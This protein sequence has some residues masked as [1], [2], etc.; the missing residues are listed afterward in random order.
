MITFHCREC[1]ASIE[2]EGSCADHP[3]AIV[4]S[5]SSAPSSLT[6]EEARE[7]GAELETM[8]AEACELF[9]ARYRSTKD[10]LRLIL[11]RFARTSARA[12]RLRLAG[13]ITAAL[14]NERELTRIYETLPKEARW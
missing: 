8:S 5:V 7:L 4:D 2:A 6:P 3:T 12:K 9:F 1:G 13:R 10:P 11:V 14:F